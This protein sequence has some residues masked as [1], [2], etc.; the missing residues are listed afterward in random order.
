MKALQISKIS[1]LNNMKNEE[2]AS[3]IKDSLRLTVFGMCVLASYCVPKIK[4]KIIFVCNEAGSFSGNIK[5]LFQYANSQSQ[6][7]D[8]MILTNSEKVYSSLIKD[9]Y[10]AFLY[11]SYKGIW[12]LLTAKK[13]VIENGMSIE[14]CGICFRTKVFQLWHGANLKYMV[15][16]WDEIRDRSHIRYS[17]NLLR[18]IKVN[19]PKYEFILSPSE[20]YKKNT[21]EKS[22]NS[23]SV[24]VAGYPRNDIFF[25]EEQ[26]SDL[27]GADIEIFKKVK[28]HRENGGKVALYCPTWR[29]KAIEGE[30]VSPLNEEKLKE[31]LEKYNILLI[32]KKHHRDKRVLTKSKHKL[33]D[34]YHHSLDIYPL[35]KHTDLLVSDYSSI[36]FDYLL[37]NKP[38]VFFP[39][40][41]NQYMT[42]DRLFQ[43]DYDEFTPGKKCITQ[44]EL[45]DEI[46][47]ALESKDYYLKER[48]KVKNLVFDKEKCENS[49]AFIWEEILKS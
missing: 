18:D 46:A 8:L 20:F 27:E 49:S 15:K 39:Y 37:L 7:L 22:F 21:F 36:F 13:V 25:K 41:Y 35:M 31:Y 43:Y 5:P 16:Q 48:E 47:L 4:R 45:F 38:V 1:F 32:L 6:N 44:Q 30:N 23:K 2:L 26:A 34:V 28:E 17:T 42:R 12:H 11:P 3:V 40:D 9:N 29:D 10:N 24:F 33:I 14:K 19:I